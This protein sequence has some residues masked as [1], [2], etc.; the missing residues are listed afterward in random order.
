MKN[1]ISE[2]KKHLYLYLLFIKSCLINELEYRVNFFMGLAVESGYLLAKSIYIIVV[3]KNN[4]HFNGLTPDSILLFIGT[5][6]FMTGIYWCVFAINF[7]RIPEYV[8]TG[9]FDILLTKPVSL[10]FITTLRYVEF[11]SILPNIGGGLVM[12]IVAWNRL[13]M[14]VSAANIGF[15]VLFICLGLIATYAFFMIPFLISFWTIKAD[16]LITTSFALW[17]FNNMPMHIYSKWIQR[18]G[19]FILPVFLI[20]NPAPSYLLGL[21]GPYRVAAA[22]ILPFVLLIIS[23]LLWK[24]ALRRYASANG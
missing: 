18:I 7:F 16:S 14:A 8:R 12:I 21:I 24:T 19:F 11:G 4:L 22:V 10:Q 3:Y 5:Y 20:T 17:D 9:Q 6:T 15:F 13:G 23:R 1:I 2:L